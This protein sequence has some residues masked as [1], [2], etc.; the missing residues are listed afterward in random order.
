MLLL[1]VLALLAMFG[2]IAVAFVVLTG[3]AQRSAKSVER[4]EQSVATTNAIS[5]KKLLH[6]AALQVLRGPA[7]DASGAAVPNSVMGTHSLLEGIYGVNG[8][9]GDVAQNQAGSSPLTT[10]GGGPYMYSCPLFINTANEA[11]WAT[12]GQ[13]IW[14]AAPALAANE[15]VAD[16]MRYVGCV[17]TMISGPAKGQSVRI[18][19][20]DP[21]NN[22]F[23][24]TGFEGQ[25]VSTNLPTRGWLMVH[26]DFF[27]GSY[28]VN[29]VPFSGTGF[30][31]NVNTGAM[32][33]R[34]DIST[35]GLDPACYTNAASASWPLALLPNAE[36]NRAPEDY[37]ASANSDYTAADFQH[38]LLAAQVPGVGTLPSMHRPALANYWYHRLYNEIDWASINVTD[39]VQKWTFILQPYGPNYDPGA[40]TDAAKQKVAA[41]IVNLKRRILMRPLREDHPNFTGSNPTAYAFNAA[42]NP[43]TNDVTAFWERGDGNSQWDV[44]NDGDGVPDSVWVDLG[45]PVRSTPDGRQYKPLFAILCVDLD[46]RLNLNVHGSA[47]QTDPAYYQSITTS[48]P[49]FAGGVSQTLPR[50][51]GYGPAEINLRPLFVDANDGANSE[52]HELWRYQNVLGRHWE[53]PSSMTPE[54]VR[55]NN[56]LGLDGRYGQ[57]SL[58]NVASPPAVLPGAGVTNS[59]DVLN[60]NKWL[61]YGGDYWN[62][63]TAGTITGSGAYGTPPDTYGYGAVGLDTAGRPIYAYMGAGTADNPYELNLARDVARGLS[64]SNNAADNPFSVAELERILRPYDKDAPRL[65]VRLAALT[66]AYGGANSILQTPQARTAVTTESWDLPCPSGLLTTDK[67]TEFTAEVTGNPPTI[68]RMPQELSNGLGLNFG[69][70]KLI[71]LLKVKLARAVWSDPDTFANKDPLTGTE[72]KTIVQSVAQRLPA[73]L[74]AEV[75]SN[76]KMNLNRPFG[77]GQDDNG[78][79]VVDEPAKIVWD[80]STNAWVVDPN[81]PGESSDLTRQLNALGGLYSSIN[82]D[83]TNGVDVTGAPTAV[84]RTM[85][86]QLYARFLYV[87]AMALVDRQGVEAELTARLGRNPSQA[88]YARYL[89]QWAVNVV[90]FRD[91]DAIM[92]PFEYDIDPFA[93]GWRVDGIVG[94]AAHA[95]PDDGFSYRGLVWGTER[96]ELLI[97]ETLAFHDRRTQDTASEQINNSESGNESR[98]GPGRTDDS[99][100]DRRDV[101]YDQVFKPQGSLFIELYNPWTINEP[102]PAEMSSAIN[103][104]IDLTKFTPNVPASQRSPVWRLAIVDRAQAIT[105]PD[106]PALTPERTVYFVGPTNVPTLPV[107]NAQVQFRPN[108]DFAGKIARIM[109]GRYMLI[110]PGEAGDT[111]SST[112]YLGFRQ[113]QN[114]GNATTATTRRI[115]LTPDANPDNP[116]S[117]PPYQ[118]SVHNT[119]EDDGSGNITTVD[120]LTQVSIKHPAA[121]VINQPQRL[122]ISEPSNGYYDNSPDGANQPSGTAYSATTGYAPGWDIPLDVSSTVNSVVK[123]AIQN[124]GRTDNVKV[125][126]LQRLANPLLPYDAA[127]NPYRT[128]DSMPIDLYAFNGIEPDERNHVTGINNTNEN[129]FYARQRGQNNGGNNNL[130]RQEPLTGTSPSA[131]TNAPVPTQAASVYH[132]RVPLHNSLAY[133]NNPF[134]TPDTDANRIGDPT[135]PFPWL[136]WLNRPFANHLELMLV[137]GDKSYELLKR[138]GFATS[139]ANLYQPTALPNAAFPQ[140]PDFFFS[141]APGGGDGSQLH[142]LLEYV[143]V[144]SLFAGTETQANPTAA[145]LGSHLF[146]PPFNSISDYREPGRINLN[147]IYNQK[148]FEGLM[149]AFPGMDSST[150]WQNLVRSRRGYD[151]APQS[152]PLGQ[153]INPGAPRPYSPTEFAKP[154]R[155]AAGAALV[156]SLDSDPANDVLRYDREINA[157]LLR[158][159]STGNKPLFQSPD[160]IAANACNNT[161]RNPYFRYQ[162]LM[163]LGNLVTTRSNVYAVWITVGYFEVTPVATPDVTRWPDGYQLGRELG[164]DTGEIE[165]RR[166]FYIFDRTIPVGF[167]RGQDLNVEKAILVNRFIE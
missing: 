131:N 4:I 108:D 17:L 46:G 106:D 145:Q 124:D 133:L 165:R 104:G 114:P 139:T 97:T 16:R 52:Q 116:T 15:T 37:G 21:T 161:D 1:L 144:P 84:D 53:N 40:L 77:N 26:G 140:L 13:L 6:Q 25:T 109:P 61:P 14:I 22:R 96:P 31:Y 89:A 7:V 56:I 64:N 2:L 68:P 54:A 136:T 163:R 98:T 34:L 95:S 80:T 93:N 128:I 155:S 20:Y 150:V 43:T 42:I 83:G 99:D 137:P 105:D 48:N 119:T 23:H 149:K 70:V 121:A 117:I 156:P 142:R 102:R 33:Q 129:E 146:Y 153:D 62:T 71:D 69:R 50:G 122:S 152:N 159:D 8:G 44:D 59:I 82:F 55:G 87:L 158:A 154:F 123:D 35:L 65:P 110:G 167:Q 88:E 132:L 78:N 10:N 73:L 90:D 29:G 81:F 60:A 18:V 91:R 100:A 112:T 41:V 28:V 94:N 162:N 58:L 19:G 38:M 141:Q 138:Y 164:V 135:N 160:S 127:T 49:Q 85:A 103:G 27:Y 39:P 134:G 24:L 63:V 101:S 92:T 36:A 79:G 151:A 57:L 118:V 76:L 66:P 130:W 107:D 143:T 148:V 125:I 147:T 51:Q 86:R 72:V 11:T 9:V 45:M 5:A 3:Q 113:N 30:G 166:A 67:V 157:T 75:L 12:G 32:D 111:D 115:V 120:D 126:H 74:P 47:A